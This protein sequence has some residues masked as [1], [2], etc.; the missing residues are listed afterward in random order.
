MPYI[1]W[2]LSLRKSIPKN[3]TQHIIHVCSTL[4][5][6]NIESEKS[7]TD[8][9]QAKEYEF[10]TVDDV[11]KE[12]IVSQEILKRSILRKWDIS[13]FPNQKKSNCEKLVVKVI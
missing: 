1:Q 12:R 3:T 9:G 6:E 8:Y 7:G 4:Y 13:W 2:S 10:S 11:T 5:K